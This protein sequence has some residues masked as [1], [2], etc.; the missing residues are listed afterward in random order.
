MKTK[1][2]TEKEG[3]EESIWSDGAYSETMSSSEKD[4]KMRTFHMKHNEEMKYNCT[5]CKVKI[6]AHNKDWHAGMCDGCFNKE[7]FPDT[8]RK[9]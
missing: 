4:A 6:S 5:K 8:M 7:F 3:D 2:A 9:K 1:E